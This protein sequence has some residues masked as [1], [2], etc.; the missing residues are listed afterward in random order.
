MVVLDAAAGGQIVRKIPDCH[1]KPVH[2]IILREA[3]PFVGDGGD[4]HEIFATA[5]A[6]GVIKLW[7]IRSPR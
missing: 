6:D 4:E 2:R 1:G 7:D 5:A 3:N